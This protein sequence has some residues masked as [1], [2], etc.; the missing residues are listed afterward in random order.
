[1]S[2]LRRV[3]NMSNDDLLRR[4]SLVDPLP[5]GN[6][7]SRPPNL[8]ALIEET[9]AQSSRTSVRHV[10]HPRFRPILLVALGAG[11]LLVPAALAFHRQIVQLFQQSTGDLKGSYSVTVSGL[12]PASL[13]GHWTITFSPI[14][15]PGRLGGA[16]TRFHDGKL[17]ADGGYTQRYNSVGTM[18]FLRDDSGPGQCAET[19]TGGVYVVRFSGSTISLKAVDPID[20]CTKRYDVLNGRTF[21]LGKS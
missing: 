6:R 8:T 15:E 16:Y 9:L 3:S 5:D 17:V 2:E 4:V 12:K 14:P 11:V 20:R 18:V 7:D 10:A 21:E 13:N 19:T 1:M